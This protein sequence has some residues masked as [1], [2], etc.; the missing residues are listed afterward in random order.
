MIK[1]NITETEKL[2]L[3]IKN[4]FIDLIPQSDEIINNTPI[5]LI[6]DHNRKE[7]RDQIFLQLHA[8]WKEDGDISGE[9][10]IGKYGKA[11]LIYTDAILNDKHFCHTAW[12][13]L[14]HIFTNSINN[15]LFEEAE[16]DARMENDS[17]IRNGMAF[18][19]EFIA[20]DIAIRIADNEPLSPFWQIQDQLTHLINEAVNKNVLN[21][22]LLS[23]YCAIVMDDNTV[24][25]MVEAYP[26][27]D[28]GFSACDE[29]KIKLISDL[30]HTLDKQLCNESFWFV[31]RE[32]LEIIG[33][34]I[35]RLW[36]CC[37][38]N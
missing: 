20:E 5:I 28:I 7:E 2:V 31:S 23:F 1:I 27:A 19:S 32:T 33:K 24:D 8:E 25:A 9:A 18:W 38:C 26:D 17:L 6:S 16:Y 21:V 30:L 15:E 22:Y 29:T 37:W 34:H 12:H 35:N 11:V 3:L 10:I 14:G 13:E 36:T 4:K